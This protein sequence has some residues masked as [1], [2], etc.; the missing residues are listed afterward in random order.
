MKEHE[1]VRD[2]MEDVGGM[3]E[4]IYLSVRSQG[5]DALANASLQVHY[6]LAQTLSLAVC[7]S[8]CLGIPL[9]NPLTRFNP[10]TINMLSVESCSFSVVTSLL[11][12]LGSPHLTATGRKD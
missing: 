5:D 12:W 10:G 6:G 2:E 8:V 9:T 7:L 11:L 1:K 4:S 3:R